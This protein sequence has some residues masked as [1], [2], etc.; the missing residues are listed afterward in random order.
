MN[1]L[2]MI[3]VIALLGLSCV[4]QSA[5]AAPRIVYEGTL[6]NAGT[7][8]MELDGHPARDST[9]SGRYFYTRFGVDIPLHGTPENLVEPL[10]L[11]DLTD[12]GSEYSKARFDHP[13]AIWRGVL[14]R[15]G[16]R[17]QWVDARTGTTRNF[18][19][20]RVAEYDP[21]E[22]VRGIVEQHKPGTGGVSDTEPAEDPE[23]GIIRLSDE[24]NFK[25]VPYETLKFAGHAQPFGPEIG[26]GVVAYRMWRDPRTKFAWPR[27]SRYPNRTIMARINRLLEQRHW[28]LSRDALDCVATRYTSDGPAAGTLGGFDEEK[29]QVTWLST[30]LMGITDSGSI[31]CGGAHPDNHYDFYTLDLLHGRY[32]D[33]NLIIDARQHNKDGTWEA[34]PALERFIRTLSAQRQNRAANKNKGKEENDDVSCLDASILVGYLDFALYAPDTF[35]FTVSDVPHV[36]GACLG[37]QLDVKL[38]ALSPILRP[39]AQ[40][41]LV[42]DVIPRPA[43]AN[44]WRAGD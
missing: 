24:I 15:S 18:T 31:F 5:R 29:V 32:L 34:S 8:V 2:R 4:C 43:G 37:P 21:Y 22:I 10:P 26:N 3:W 42:P 11:A 6:Q 35:S 14:D 12:N 39:G 36:M 1:M 7:V 30:A 41:Y 19:L 25:Q 20:K 13:A 44:D 33:W 9:L 28:Q 17:G 27:L 38:N 16:Y 40:R 23:D